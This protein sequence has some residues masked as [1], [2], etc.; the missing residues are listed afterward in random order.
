MNGHPSVPVVPAVLALAEQEGC[1]GAAFLAAVIAGIEFE[2]RLGALIGAPH[3]AAGFHATGTLG[4]FGAAAA[5]SHLLGLDRVAWYHAI[6]LAGTQA[7]GLKSGFGTMAKPLHAGR[8]ASNGLLAALLAR[9]GF[10][11]N[12]AIIETA[13]GFAPTHAGGA[14][15]AERL[16]RLG[17][18]FL[19]T[20]TLFKY[21]A[22]CYLTHAPIEA[23]SQLRAEGLRAGEIE[24]VEVRGSTICVGVCDIAEP[25]TGLEGKFS[26]RA[27]TAMALLGDD[28][29]DPATFSDER[30][31]AQDLRAL[32]DRVVFSPELGLPATRATVTVRAKGRQVS[33]EADTG[34]PASD[35]EAQWSKLSAKF[36]ALAEP[37]IGRES[38]RAL[39]G[40]I[41]DIEN[42]S[43]VR[44]LASLLR[45]AVSA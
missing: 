8:A 39:H 45:P 27:T 40:A 41:A 38:A 33:V 12:P 17:D 34:R 7:A 29:S 4:T 20:E 35:R 31:R 3:Y 30:M 11:G 37:V 9:G 22:S 28:T 5:A 14:I 15:D 16:A 2:C 18:R 44:D 24:S 32:R 43:S 10:T 25:S 26:L 21:H 6:G 19:I 13:Q 1:D 36:F 23:A 42:V